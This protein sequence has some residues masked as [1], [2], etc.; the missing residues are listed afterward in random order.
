M[1]QFNNC[2][3]F[4]LQN[5]GSTLYED[6]ATG[7]RSKFGITEKLLKQIDYFVNDADKLTVADAKSIYLQHF[8]NRYRFDLYKSDKVA[9]KILDM[10]VNMGPRQAAL[11]VQDAMEMKG[12]MRDGIIGWH[13]RCEINEWTPENLIE[14]IILQCKIFYTALANSDDVYVKNLPGWLNRAGKILA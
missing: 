3:D 9:A 8:W 14:K 1:A 7:E 5:E 6:K 13:T 11:L 10:F 12:P 2:I 4:V